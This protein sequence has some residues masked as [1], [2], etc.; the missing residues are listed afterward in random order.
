MKSILLI[1]FNGFLGSHIEKYLLSIPE[2][3]VTTLGR[4]N[5]SNIIVDFVHCI[6][7]IPSLY[8]VVIH[9]AGK[10]HRLSKTEFEKQEFHQV[11][12]VGTQN[13]LDGLKIS[14]LP[15]SFIYISSVSVYGQDSG[16]R[17]DEN[18]PLKALDPYGRSKIES[19]KIVAEW[20]CSNHV[21]CTILR[22]PLIVGTNPPG[23]LE[24]MINGIQKGYYLNIA[25]GNAKKSMVL[26]EDVAKSIMKV[27][28]IGGIYNLTDGYHPTL[29][30]L[31]NHISIQLG[32]SKPLSIPLWLAK[33]IAKLG[34]LIG[35]KAPLNKIRLKKITTDLTFD[36]TLAR[37]NFGW[38]PTPVLKGFSIT[39]F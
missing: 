24:A 25:G 3:T 36:D 32:I 12:V 13:I 7:K 37:K 8:D 18:T 22:L 33:I 26:V 27:S 9:A 21:V 38:N 14:G 29:A 10:A 16:I 39:I 5:K 1:G 23:N 4:N 2:Y 31:S 35:S 15:K 28:P 34:D 19:E 20:C 11:N 17:I 6:P 30:E